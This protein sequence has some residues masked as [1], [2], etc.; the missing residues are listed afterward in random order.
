MLFRI[1]LLL[2]LIPLID[3]LVLLWIAQQTSAG[4]AFALVL[5]GI[6]AG[7][8]VMRWQ[9]FYALGRLRR[10]IDAGQ[11]PAA[12]IFDNFLIF[13]AGILFLVPGVLTDMA[14]IAL[15]LPPGRRA[16]RAYLRRRMVL[17][18]YGT[19]AGGPPTEA[20]DTIIESHVVESRVIE[21]SQAGD[22]AQHR[23]QNP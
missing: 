19:R 13:V 18:M 2:I 21:S 20:R 23:A 16:V 9:G 10:D 15:L 22:E 1:L 6:V 3:L 11:T 17:G 4:F 5:A 14:G 8:A 7:V 12:A